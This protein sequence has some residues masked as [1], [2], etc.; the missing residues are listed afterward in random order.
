MNARPLY[1]VSSS[2]DDSTLP[3]VATTRGGCSFTPGDE[4]WR[5]VEGVT[6]V[7]LNFSRLNGLITPQ[8]LSQLKFTLIWLLGNKAAATVLNTF[9]AF[10]HLLRVTGRSCADPLSEITQFDI[11]SYRAALSPKQLNRLHTLAIL[12]R[13]WHQLGAQGLA[14]DVVPLL[15]A[16]RLKAPPSGEPVRTMCPFRGPLTALEDE[17]YQSAVNSAFAQGRITEEEFF[18]VWLSRAIGQRPA[19]TAALKVCDLT[20][21]VKPDGSVE[22]QIRMPRVK[23]R[24]ATH[25]R[26]SW[27]VRPLIQQ[28]GAPLYEYR[29]KLIQRFVG[30]VD[31]LTQLPLFP[32]A[33]PSEANSSDYVWHKTSGEMGKLLAGVTDN[34]QAFSER[35]GENLQVSATRL[36]RTVGTRAAQEGHGE[37]VIAEILDHSNVASARFYVEAVPDIVARIDAATARAMAPLARAF[38]GLQPKS[39]DAADA[40]ADNQI[41][42]FR[43]DQS[44][45]SMGNC[46][47]GACSFLAPVACYTCRN[48][49]P[50]IDG[51]H[52]AVLDELLV[53]REDQLARLGARVA[54]THDRTILAVTEVIQICEKLKRGLKG[55]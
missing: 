37:L 7:S 33:R 9:N 42:D 40:C 48:F 17:A 30:V 14:S 2:G 22:F 32:G 28:I 12:L 3:A 27:K 23:Q 39:A 25:P 43:F 18:A 21:E 47:G 35:T 50:W 41:L 53:R 34:L 11:L 49:R 46:S 54:S 15:N 19:Q 16:M 8:V 20:R 4:I 38:Q 26:T 24:N 52:Q 13:K 1:Q 36:R 10:T 29:E 5:I 55:D 45:R 31:D 44:G 51:P 6:K